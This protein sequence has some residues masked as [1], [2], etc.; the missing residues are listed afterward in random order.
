M[1]HVSEEDA[2]AVDRCAALTWVAASQADLKLRSSGW[3][4]TIRGGSLLAE[5][6]N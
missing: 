1:R 2:A 6:E 3:A 5:F 4:S